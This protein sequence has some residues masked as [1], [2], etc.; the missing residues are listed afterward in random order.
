MG[1]P[2]D[3]P[4]A[5]VGYGIAGTATKVATREG[6]RISPWLTGE[7]CVEVAESAS[8]IDSATAR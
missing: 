1:K 2:S 3:S 8:D 4:D 7:W 5:V 6:E